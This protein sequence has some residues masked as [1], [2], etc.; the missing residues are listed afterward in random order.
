M[1]EELM[2]KAL[3]AIIKKLADMDKKINYLTEAVETLI[4]L[5]VERQKGG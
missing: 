2:K 1:S 4:E 5:E 3:S